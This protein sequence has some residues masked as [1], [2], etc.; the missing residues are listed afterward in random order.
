MQSIATEDN[1]DIL[2]E[3]YKTGSAIKRMKDINS[4]NSVR[5]R[6]FGRIT[7]LRNSSDV[8]S[9]FVLKEKIRSFEF[10]A[11]CG[12]LSKVVC[13]KIFRF[14]NERY[15]TVTLTLTFTS[16]AAMPIT[17]LVTPY[18]ISAMHS[19]FTMPSMMT[20]RGFSLEMITTIT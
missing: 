11:I 19:D 4:A 13:S 14:S 16:V 6:S 1:R 15:S 18:I 10:R 8:L 17:V 7:F 3:I 2:Q 12:F 20:S 5:G 9:K